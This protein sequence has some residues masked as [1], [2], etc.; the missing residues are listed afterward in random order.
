MAVGST[1]TGFRRDRSNSRL[2][3]YY[4]GTREA[5]ISASGLTVADG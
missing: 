2:D 1:H 5:D 3:I 4:E